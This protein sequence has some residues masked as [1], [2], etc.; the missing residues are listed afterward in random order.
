MPAQP[1]PEIEQVVPGDGRRE[2]HSLPP[3]V[4]VPP[5]NPTDALSLNI[6]RPARRPWQRAP[7]VWFILPALLAYGALF[8]YPTLRAFYLSLFDW[9]GV[10]PIGGTIWFDNFARLLR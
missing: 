10:D 6:P 4:A 5:L 9:S 2:S 3:A 8:V 7:F 1:A